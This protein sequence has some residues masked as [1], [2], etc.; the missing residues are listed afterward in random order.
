M[1]QRDMRARV[2]AV[3]ALLKEHTPEVAYDER[4]GLERLRAGGQAP[5]WAAEVPRAR[6]L[7]WPWFVLLTIAGA[8]FVWPAAP[9]PVREPPKPALTRAPVPVE[10]RPVREAESPVREPE[11]A[12]V[13]APEPAPRAVPRVHRPAKRE[14]PVPAAPAPAAEERMEEPAAAPA[15]EPPRALDPRDLVEMRQVAQAER[16][17]A[18]DPARALALV[19]AGQ[20]EYP[21]GYF[22]EER[23][24]LEI[25]ALAKLGRRD[26]A[27]AAAWTFFQD[28]PRSSYRRRIED[29]LR[30]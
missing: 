4:A 1:K 15:T 8:V 7:W 2:R 18:R 21:R 19:R 30:D 17:L 10:P 25:L 11:R 16:A 23:S 9:A 3:E 12:P 6:R 28:Y 14:Q 5:A 13:V 29:A 20:A 26:Q 27:R 22:R 24:Y